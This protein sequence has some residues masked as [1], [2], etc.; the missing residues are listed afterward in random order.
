MNILFVTG[1][2]AENERD[3][4]L[5]GMAHAVYKSAVG[6][7]M[8][9]HRVRILTA[10]NQER[11]WHYHGLEVT[12]V[13]VSQGIDDKSGFGVLLDIFKREYL[14]EKTIRKMNR[15]EAIDIIQYTGWFGIGLFHF[16]HIPAVMRISSYTKIQL[17]H[18]YSGMKKCLLEFVEYLAAKRMNYVFA[19][20]EN[21]A[22]GLEQDIRKK[23]GVIE[24]PFMQEE[25]EW[26]DRLLRSR[27]KGKRY[28]LFFGR[29]SVD[30]GILVIRDILYRTLDKNQ[31][32]HFVF[33]GGGGKYNGVP[34]EQELSQA[35]KEYNSR[36]IFLGWLSKDRLMPVVNGAEMVLMPSLADNFPNSCA[37]AM[38]LGKIV[39][40]TD[41]SSMEQF[42]D[43]GVN[44]YLTEIGNADM[45]YQCV[46]V[47][48]N[49]DAKQ[50]NNISICARRRIKELDLE[51]YSKRM[52]KIYSRVV[53][54]MKK[55]GK[56]R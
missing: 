20:G 50:K 33:A 36:V 9:G 49:M 14:I 5:G 47:V 23:V 41:G 26:D 45:L 10:A 28:L 34:I 6:M 52:E 44:G 42:I 16:M 18:N 11:Q 31:D 56:L 39:V 27:L 17:V 40:G 30:K 21:L 55:E 54:M 43:N 25:I 2:F 35:A 53:R 15:K 38:A 37:E 12:S 3:T 51:K 22:R 4:A 13:K 19:P 48:L 7:Q 29:M 24:T 46:D 32:I 1:I 8:R